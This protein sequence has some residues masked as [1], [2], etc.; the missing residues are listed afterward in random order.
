MAG[1]DNTHSHTHSQKAFVSFRY[2]KGR[3]LLEHFENLCNSCRL[4]RSASLP[5]PHRWDFVLPGALAGVG[6]RILCALLCAP[7][8]DR[9]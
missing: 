8:T 4:S 5:T 2:F 3:I 7:Y 1:S 6:K 9:H